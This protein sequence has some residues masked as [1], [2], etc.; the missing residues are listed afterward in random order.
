MNSICHNEHTCRAT[1]VAQ[2]LQVFISKLDN[3]SLI[4]RNQHWKERA[5][6]HKLS[7]DLF[8]NAITHFISH[9]PHTQ[10]KSMNENNFRISA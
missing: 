3:L 8:I 4:P 6:S 9:P 1:K 10:N 5:D 7:S 2:W